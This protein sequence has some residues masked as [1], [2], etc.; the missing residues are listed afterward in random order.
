MVPAPETPEIE[1]TKLTNTQ[2]TALNLLKAGA[3]FRY[4][5]ESGWHGEKFQWSLMLNG[6]KMK[7]FGGACFRAL[8]AAG[9][10]FDRKASGFTGMAT[11]YSLKGGA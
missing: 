8:E 4:G 9:F 10:E 5:L 3:C 2:A 1:M 7:G 11:H 6:K